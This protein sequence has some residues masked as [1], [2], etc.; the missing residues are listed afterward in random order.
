M[1][2]KEIIHKLIKCISNEKEFTSILTS[3]NAC[4][5]NEIVKYRDKHGDSLLHFAARV[6]SINIMRLLIHYGADPESINEHGRRPIHEA[7]DSYDCLSYLI[8]ECHVD[9]DAIKR[10]DWTPL[11]IAAMKGNLDTVK[12][13]V[14]AGAL[15]DRTTKDGRT[16]LYLAVQEGHILVSK[17]LT[18]QCPEAILIPTKSGRLPIHAAASLVFD[19]VN[20]NK[21]PTSSAYIITTYLLSHSTTPITTLLNCRDHSGRTILLDSAVSHN[22]SLLQYLLNQGANPND[23]DSLGRNMI[24]HASMLNQLDV[25]QLLHNMGSMINWD[26]SDG[27]DNWTPLMHAARQGHL[28]IVMYLVE[29][30]KVD[31]ALK[32]K[33]GRTAYDIACLWKHTHIVDYLTEKCG[34]ISCDV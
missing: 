31:V 9:M 11:M 14:E 34:V 6:P 27:W 22:L 5:V 29:E 23:V 30:V 20:N 12:L 3:C 28:P 24:H 32:D 33:H 8:H 10:G 2:M 15:L 19:G 7:I 26:M 4:L 18:N 17:Y 1:S 25:L 21:E 13:L 16:A